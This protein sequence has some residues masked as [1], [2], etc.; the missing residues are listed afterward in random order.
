LIFSAVQHLFSFDAFL[1]SIYKYRLV[2]GQ[3]AT[4]AAIL[5]VVTMFS[6]GIGLLSRQTRQW[7]AVAASILFLIFFIATTSSVLRGIDTDCG[8]ALGERRIDWLAAA[9]PLSLAL[10]CLCFLWGERCEES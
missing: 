9:K 2:D 10:A 8:C 3:L 5:I 4:V 1:V 7:Y 6:C